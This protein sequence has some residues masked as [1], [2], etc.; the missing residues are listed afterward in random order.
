MEP[1]IIYFL[2]SF[3]GIF[4]TTFLVCM[5]SMTYERNFREHVNNWIV[6]AIS[7][8]IS[9]IVQYNITMYLLKDGY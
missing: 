4:M 8:I 2:L 1:N 5:C 9:G 6:F 3:L 7:G